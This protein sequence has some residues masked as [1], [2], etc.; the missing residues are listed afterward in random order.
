MRLVQAESKEMQEQI[1][2]LYLTAFPEAELKPFELI[3]E[4]QR[5]GSADILMAEDD[6]EF[7]G[8]AI[9]VSYE[10]L[11]LLDYFA[12]D[13]RKRGSGYGSAALQQLLKYYEGRQLIIEIESSKVPCDNIEERIRREHFY[14]RNGMKDLDITIELCGVTMVLLSNQTPLTYAEYINV[15]EQVYGSEIASDIRL[16]SEKSE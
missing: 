12:I 11:V 16:L 5:E 4:K 8:L 14:H 10:N 1:R 7:C 15:Y 6:G 3:C 2:N 13:G 9:T